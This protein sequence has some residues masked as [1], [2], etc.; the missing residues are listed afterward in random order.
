MLANILLLLAL[1][2]IPSQ[3]TPS[4]YEEA[5]AYEVYAAILPSE[6]PLKEAHAKQLIIRRETTS[7]EMCLKPEKEFQDKLGPAISAYLEL[8]KKQWLLQPRFSLELPYQFIDSAKVKAIFEHSDWDEYYRLYPKSGGLID[9]SA[10]GFNDDKT[11]AVVYM[12]HG[13]G[14][15]CGGGGFHVLEKVDG[16]WK[17]LEWK[18][19]RCYWIS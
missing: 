1:L 6:W 17:P 10:V 11:V 4:V 7:Y 14:P 2:T 15:L 16:K 18:G 5:E 13:C 3:S 9:L 8:N 12:G 19:S